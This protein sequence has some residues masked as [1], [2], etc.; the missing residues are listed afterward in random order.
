MAA[1]D[2][3]GLHAAVGGQVGRAEREALHAGR[4]A[5]DLLDVGDAT[6]G[7]E[8]GVDQQRLG[9]T[10]LGLEL[11]EQAIDVVDVLGAFDLG[12]HDDVERL[13]RLRC[14]SGS[15]VVEDPRRVEAVD[16]SPE[17]G[18]AD[19]DGRGRPRP[20]R[21]VPLPCGRR[22]RRLRGCRAGCRPSVRSGAPW[23]ASS[24]STAGRSGS[25]DSE[26]TGSRARARG[27]RRPA[28]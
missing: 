27:R 11:G 18:V 19:V 6:S 16:P 13:R 7:L 25:S 28:A 21:R 1:A 20:G 10:G 24:R 26:G 12:D 22:A 9:E 2:A 4:G 15:E 8:D 23:T 3:G 17:L 14:T 5:A